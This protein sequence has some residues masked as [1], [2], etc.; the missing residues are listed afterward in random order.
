MTVENT[1]VKE[2]KHEEKRPD[3][4]F[5]NSYYHGDNLKGDGYVMTHGIKVDPEYS[6]RYL[7][8]VYSPENN[9]EYKIVEKR[10]NE[11]IMVHNDIKCMLNGEY[12]MNREDM[13]MVFSVI[14]EEFPKSESASEFANPIYMLDVISDLSGMKYKNMFDMLEYKFK[15]I[16]INELDNSHNILSNPNI[17]GRFF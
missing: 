3:K 10:V 13:N 11:I 5:N 4:I 7:N 15:E 9:M 2:K 14:I 17:F 8:D 1:I 6:K 16:L 12:K